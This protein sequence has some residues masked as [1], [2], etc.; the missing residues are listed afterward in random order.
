M[1]GDSVVRY[2]HDIAKK[3]VL[4]R[5]QELSLFARAEGGD[6][7][8]YHEVIEAHLKMVVFIARHH[9]SVLPLAD[10]IE[11]GNLGMM[12]AVQK[13]NAAYGCRFATYAVWWVR[14]YIERAISN[15]SSIVRIPVH[16]RQEMN[17]MRRVESLLAIE[18]SRA[19]TVIEIANH[20]E[21]KVS[22]VQSLLYLAQPQIQSDMTDDLGS[23]CDDV[24]SPSP[25]REL[26]QKQKTATVTDWLASLNPRECEVISA[27]F[28]LQGGEMK[29]LEMVGEGMGCSKER[30]RQI[31]VAALKKIRQDVAENPFH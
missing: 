15:Q 19:P 18:Y 2:L 13:F 1:E 10:R 20:M 7:T 31:Q 16:V 17:A 5:E 14:A 25:E 24:Q 8:A 21:T 28:G 3:T 29:T 23:D 9:Q 12:H 22:H 30:V 4:D 6:I 27:R 26:E 11:E